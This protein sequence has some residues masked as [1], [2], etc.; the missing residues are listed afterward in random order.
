MSRKGYLASKGA[1]PKNLKW[2]ERLWKL[3]AE[4]LCCFSKE[5]HN[6]C[7]GTFP[8]EDLT[9]VKFG[10]SK[11]GN[12]WTFE[13]SGAKIRLRSRTAA[14]AQAWYESLKE[15]V[16]AA[17]AELEEP[18]DG[19][20]G[21]EGGEEEEPEVDETVEETGTRSIETTD[22]V[23]NNAKKELIAIRKALE[24]VVK[25]LRTKILQHTQSGKEELVNKFFEKCD[26]NG[27]GE[28]D[29]EEFRGII[30]TVCKLTRDQMGDAELQTLFQVMDT[31][32][33][34]SIGVAEFKDFLMEAPATE[35]PPSPKCLPK[36]KSRLDQM[37][38][39]HAMKKAKIE[40]KKK[41][42]DAEE[43][44]KLDQ[45]RKSERRISTERALNTAERLYNNAFAM[46]SRLQE[47]RVQYDENQKAAVERRM[48]K[49]RPTHQK[50]KGSLGDA[51]K[52]GNRLHR[53]AER[54]DR[55][56]ALRVEESFMVEQEYFA[57]FQPAPFRTRRHLDLYTEAECR[58]ER[59]DTRRAQSEQDEFDK[60]RD[61]SMLR[62]EDREYNPDRIHELYAEHAEKQKKLAT[63]LA[64]KQMQEAASANE[65]AP[66]S[67]RNVVDHSRRKR[68][69]I[70]DDPRSPRSVFSATRRQRD[71][72]E[73]NQLR[74]ERELA[75]KLAKQQRLPIAST[76][77]T[78]PSRHLVTGAD[79][80]VNT[81]IQT[82]QQ[83]LGFNSN[84]EQIWCADNRP[85]AN[86]MHEIVEIV[87]EAQK[88]CEASDGYTALCNRSSERLYKEHLVPDH[89]GWVR[90]VEPDRISQV[91]EF[92]DDLLRSAQKAQAELRF[93]IA[94]GEWIHGA[95]KSHPAGCPVA[96]FVYDNGVK[97]P[98]SAR[99]KAVV[100]QGP[101]EGM[102]GC[103]KHLLDLSRLLLVFSS[104]DLLQSGLD[105]IIRRFEVVDVRNYFSRPG[106]LGIRFVEVLVVVQVN[107]GTADEPDMIPHI[108]ELR[109][110]ELYFHKAQEAIA[111]A[112]RKWYSA[113]HNLY[114]RPVRD[115][116]CL[117]VLAHAVMFKPPVPHDVRVFKIQLAK[118]YGS[119]TS[120]W[121]NEFGSSRR[122]DFKKF[123]SLCKRMNCGER[124]TEF[125]QGLDPHLG[126]AISLYDFDP[127]AVSLLIHLRQRLLG[128]ADTGPSSD[129]GPTADPEAI[130]SRLSFLI[131]PITVG[132]LEPQE[133]R[134]CVSSIGLTLEEGDKSFRYL[135][136]YHR[137]PQ[138][139]AVSD[140]AWLLNLHKLID[141][142]AVHMQSTVAP[143]NSEALRH[144]TWSSASARHNKRS[145]ILRWSIFREQPDE[146]EKGDEGG[147]RERQVK[148]S[149][150]SKSEE[151]RTRNRQGGGDF[152]R[153]FFDKLER[154]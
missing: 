132:K 83:R 23:R 154:Q 89:E 77:V 129:K 125:W 105:Q 63:L 128:L 81:I 146:T 148:T 97:T 45:G 92:P 134:K 22:T 17:D 126:G 150:R 76:D 116:A 80:L 6:T 82:V 26:A 86:E 9:N 121:R 50:M 115:P 32:G 103:F 73:Q 43:Q 133:W 21:G 145:E 52:A 139:I 15:A 11:S 117:S 147:L 61:V 57:N 113:Y 55:D 67:K 99:A 10:D 38:A 141:I 98:A 143:S 104:C 35:E 66:Q 30:R 8:L 120:C 138:T 7:L 78:K 149:K 36:P 46:E 71:G 110:E 140:L 3:D 152:S 42:K 16:P 2:E 119:T 14:E 124:A 39:E 144:I 47:K 31:S 102:N 28:L 75:K 60:L 27:D 74:H 20:D 85:L 151:P 53:D 123:L 142:E 95:V 25:K 12:E 130:F 58:R 72:E 87:R 131:R 100:R 1:D 5:N 62:G 79:H 112:L 114:D 4:S 127:E 56:R 135:D 13:A 84:T 37:Y 153:A 24:S 65:L 70:I 88:N 109:L 137:S 33:A 106:R 136:M 101:S 122:L 54:R 49:N 111:P 91:E 59:A 41:R 18:E 34:G 64:E 94:G 44:A 90:N 107:R 19:M 68:P 96:L 29:M 118:R 40:V 108:C 69:S 48:L 93:L 51:A